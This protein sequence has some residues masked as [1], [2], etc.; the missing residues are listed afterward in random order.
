[1]TKNY[2]FHVWAIVLLS[3]NM[4]NIVVNR[5]RR[6]SDAEECLRLLRRTKP[7][8]RYTIMYIPSE[9]TMKSIPTEWHMYTSEGDAEVARMMH[10][11]RTALSEHPLPKVRSMLRSKIE[12]V[13]KS[14]AEVYDT[15]VRESIVSRLTGW[16][17]E[18]NEL[19]EFQ[20]SSS[21][22]DL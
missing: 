22:W 12:L 11:V 7:N 20:L 13:S 10:E 15:A 16:A 19:S 2:V 18:A 6:R 9:N 5:F 21:Y 3:G 1:M 8:K 14:H 17:R 4:Q